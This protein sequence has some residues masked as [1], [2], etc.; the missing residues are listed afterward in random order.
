MAKTS[1]DQQIDALRCRLDLLRQ[2]NGQLSGRERS[3]K[4]EA[5]EEISVALEEL[6]VAGKGLRQQNE[7]PA[8]VRRVVEAEC[9]RYQDLFE[10]HQMD[11]L[12]PMPLASL[13]ERIVWRQRSFR[14]L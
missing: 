8:D 1:L 6:E 2:P 13:K 12:S 4:G 9:Q 3:L 11:T 5:L 10:F 7:E 14:C